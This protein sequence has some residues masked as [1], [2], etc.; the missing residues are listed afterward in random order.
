MEAEDVD[1]ETPLHWA[2]YD[3]SNQVAKLLRSLG[4]TE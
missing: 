3:N 1:G 4:A 2:K